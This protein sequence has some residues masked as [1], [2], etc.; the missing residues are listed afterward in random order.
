MCGRFYIDYSIEDLIAS[1]GIANVKNQVPL[2]G[3]IYP[4]TNIPVIVKDKE[5]TLDFYRWGFNIK[6]T[7]REII[8]ARIET[9]DEKPTFRKAFCNNRCIIPASA[10]FEWRTNGKNNTKYKISIKDR[11]F[12]SLAGIYESFTDK[13]HKTYFGVVILTRP[14]SDEMSKIH[15]RM[16]V[17]IKKEDVDSWLY[18]SSLDILKAKEDLMVSNWF[19]LNI[20]PCDKTE[21]ISMFS[22]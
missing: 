4:G 3:E 22:M 6:S 21:Q 18:D 8:N 16:P 17:F 10:F 5:K 11:R 13:N 1:Y 14:A 19:N 7:S 2:K 15:H 12:L 20:E 9:V